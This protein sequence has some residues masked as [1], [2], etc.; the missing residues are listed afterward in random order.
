M[1]VVRVDGRDG[2]VERG[3]GPG[4]GAGGDGIPEPGRLPGLRI[5]RGDSRWRLLVVIQH[6][7]E[8]DAVSVLVELDV[9]LICIMFTRAVYIMFTLMNASVNIVG[10]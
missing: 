3:E 6:V 5:G 8:I 7:S 10:G 4:K 2:L 1:P 9:V